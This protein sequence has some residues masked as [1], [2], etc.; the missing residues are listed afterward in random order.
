MS[1]DAREGEHVEAAAWK[2]TNLHGKERRGDLASR[3][4]PDRGKIQFPHCPG[5]MPVLGKK[6]EGHPVPEQVKERKPR[7]VI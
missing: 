7:E 5:E 3:R 1:R 6:L 4:K 2:S